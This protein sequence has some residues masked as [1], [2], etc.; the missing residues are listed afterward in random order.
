MVSAMRLINILV[1]VIIWMSSACAGA[2]EVATTPSLASGKNGFVREH[3]ISGASKVIGSHEDYFF[4]AK[5]DGAIDK[6]DHA[7]RKVLSLAAKDSK[8][9]A[10]L[11]QPESV[12]VADDMIY[13]ADSESHLIAIFTLEGQYQGSFGAKRGGFFGGGAGV[14]LNSPRGVAIHEGIVYVADTGNGKVQLFG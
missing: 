6:I 3:A 10:I 13:V 1:L 2:T 4:V 12:A 9:G 11:K 8:G 7:G 14:E 5:Q